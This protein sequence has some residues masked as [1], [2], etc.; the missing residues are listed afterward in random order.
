MRLAL[1]SVI[2]TRGVSQIV[3]SPLGGLAFNIVSIRLSFQT[4]NN[5]H[6]LTADIHQIDAFFGCRG[7]IVQLI[8]HRFSPPLCYSA[9][10]KKRAAG[11]SFAPGF[12]DKLSIAK[13]D[14][15]TTGIFQ[16]WVGNL[17]EVDSKIPA[18]S[19]LRLIGGHFKEH[20]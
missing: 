14:R 20:R 5:P 8:V 4:R 18:R 2:S 11:S 1:R 9:V 17:P 10:E 6:N 3:G 19:F 16:F 13:W 7:C 15:Q 12:T